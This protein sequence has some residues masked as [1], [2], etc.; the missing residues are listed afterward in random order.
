MLCAFIDISW[1]PGKG[2]YTW[3]AGDIYEGNYEASAKTDPEGRYTWSDGSEY[4]GPWRN[5]KPNG[6]GELIFSP[7][8]PEASY[9]GGFVDGELTGNGTLVFEDGCIYDGSISKG[10]FEGNGTIK[11]LKAND[12]TAVYKYSGETSIYSS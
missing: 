10:L 1:S 9:I 7:V 4:V 3:T 8:K 2:R 6:E 5:N 11:Y 12:G